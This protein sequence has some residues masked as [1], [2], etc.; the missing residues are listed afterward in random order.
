LRIFAKLKVAKRNI[1]QVLPQQSGFLTNL[2]DAVVGSQICYDYQPRVAERGNGDIIGKMKAFKRSYLW[3]CLAVI[4]LSTSFIAGYLAQHYLPLGDNQG[5][6]FGLV[7]QAYSILKN[8]AYDDLPQ[9]PQIQYGMIRGM[10]QAYGDPFSSFLEP[11]QSTLENHS[12]QG[13]FGGIGVGL[14]LDEEGYVLMF[15]FP[16]SP[17]LEAGV[18]E[19]DRLMAVN[20]ILFRPPVAMEQVQAAIRGP[21]GKPVTLQLV[22]PP[23]ETMVEV[24]ILR[25][26]I[27]LP[28]V[29]WHLEPSDPAVGIVEINLIAA[30]TAEEVQKAFQDLGSRGATGF[31]LDLRDNGGGLLNAGIETA[32][33]FLKQGDIIHQQYRNQELEIYRVEK[34][35]P[36]VDIPLAILVNQNT[37]SAAEIIAGALQAQDRA[38]LVGFPTYGKDSIQLIFPLQDGSSLHVT[39]AKWWIPGLENLDGNHNLHPDILLTLDNPTTEDYIQAAI[40]AL[41]GQN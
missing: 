13:H 12:L 29:T 38:L 35:G 5:D 18:L 24:S 39:A 21:V 33:L 23:D 32:R 16:D 28:S 8:H 19:G 30:S 6:Q 11:V 7:Q 40:Q 20:G 2:R 36:L 9:D 1:P 17:A 37:A 27:P 3:A 10:L 4:L 41:S 34:P 31:L 25:R 14:G 26:E 15:P 22:H